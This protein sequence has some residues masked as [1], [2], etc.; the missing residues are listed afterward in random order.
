MVSGTARGADQ[1]VREPRCVVAVGKGHC[2]PGAS[3]SRDSPLGFVL[4]ALPLREFSDELLSRTAERRVMTGTTMVALVLRA[5]GTV[6]AEGTARGGRA[7]AGQAFGPYGGVRQRDR[8]DTKWETDW[9]VGVAGGRAQSGLDA[10]GE[11]G[12][13]P[14][15]RSIS[16]G[17]GL[18]RDEAGVASSA[19]MAVA[20]RTRT[21]DDAG[22]SGTYCVDVK[23]GEAARGACVCVWLGKSRVRWCCVWLGL[24]GGSSSGRRGRRCLLGDGRFRALDG[25]DDVGGK[26]CLFAGTACSE[27][28][29][30]HHCP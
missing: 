18:L 26:W 24:A 9:A 15:G 7:R 12:T 21:G 28:R 10:D 5:H 8:N 3:A 13:G 1:N 11:L 30:S 16:A 17:R 29:K 2:S 6:D 4:P 20:V 14:A 22:P 27:G 25:R 19:V 23:V